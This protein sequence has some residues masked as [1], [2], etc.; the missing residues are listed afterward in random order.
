MESLVFVAA[1]SLGSFFSPKILAMVF[2]MV[3]SPSVTQIL[4][5]KFPELG[6]W[7]T[8]VN[9]TVALIVGYLS[10]MAFSGDQATLQAWMEAVGLGG[11][12]LG[13]VAYTIKRQSD[14]TDEEK[15]E[16]LRK[17]KELGKK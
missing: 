11:A 1:V 9:T 12:T 6:S 15:A 8:V 5:K 2:N 16:D 10:W 14:K 13:G 7:A 17:T 3:I 4:K